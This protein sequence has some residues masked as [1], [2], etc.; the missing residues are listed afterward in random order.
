MLRKA[1]SQTASPAGG[2]CGIHFQAPLVPSQC[3]SSKSASGF[4]RPLKPIGAEST[5]TPQLLL[6]GRRERFLPAA[7]LRSC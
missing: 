3:E 7:N 1:Q 6:H 2:C 4:Y 5:E